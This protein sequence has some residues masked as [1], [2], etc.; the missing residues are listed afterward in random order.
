MNSLK[1]ALCI[2]V[3]YAM[4][5]MLFMPLAVLAN[6]F[7]Y[8]KYDDALVVDRW[9]Y[10][11]EKV[12]PHCGRKI[13]NFEDVVIRYLGKF[14]DG[15]V[16]Q[17]VG[18][19]NRTTKSLE[20]IVCPHCGSTEWFSYSNKG[21]QI[22]NIQFTKHT[23]VSGIEPPSGWDDP[24]DWWDDLMKTDTLDEFGT[25]TIRKTID[26]A[27]LNGSTDND[28]LFLAVMVKVTDTSGGE[29]EY[30]FY[31]DSDLG[32]ADTKFLPVGEY[33]LQEEF[34]KEGEGYVFG[35]FAYN[36]DVSY[37]ETEIILVRKDET[38]VITMDNLAAT[39]GSGGGG[40]DGGD[41]GNNPPGGGNN[42]PPGGG[43]GSGPAELPD[44]SG[45]GTGNNPG[46]N[47]GGSGQP[48][49]NEDGNGSG[50]DGNAN[51]PPNIT[52]PD[53][54][55]PEDFPDIDFD[56]RQPDPTTPGGT[57]QGAPPVPNNPVYRL[58]PQLNDD[59]EVFFIEF[60]D[61][62]VPLG[63]W[64]WGD[65]DM[66]LFD[67]YPPLSGMPATGIPNIAA[68]LVSLAVVFAISLLG[69][70]IVQQYDNKKTIID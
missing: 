33:M 5:S 32:W 35:S 10:F 15:D 40:G 58:V 9:E 49:D 66:W 48:D 70:I 23:L 55:G 64:H 3:I 24:P 38:T 60:D 29:T 21:Q 57:D 20:D 37:N 31:L 17:I 36:G 13:G 30:R 62:D 42:N 1:K 52:F 18:Q 41:G 47:G 50:G 28:K 54:T 26:G 63:E 45:G 11:V 46:D 65:G 69:A 6:E 14:Q 51:P 7:D 68:Y 12:G 19:L 67:E 4:L 2:T 27:A 59:D 22:K 43:D 8:S 61:L 16:Y 53:G 44:D 34:L 25:I 39:D 56:R